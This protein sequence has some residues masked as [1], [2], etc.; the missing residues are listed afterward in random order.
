[1]H[2]WV[3]AGWVGGSGGL[4]ADPVESAGEAQPTGNSGEGMRC[5][6][7]GGEGRGG[8]GRGTWFAT[9]LGVGGACGTA[10]A[11]SPDTT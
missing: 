6:H 4:G 5:V 1:M 2:A 3:R 11:I 7:R 8:E 9:C 10:T